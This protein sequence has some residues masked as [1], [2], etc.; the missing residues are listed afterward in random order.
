MIIQQGSVNTTALVVPDLW[1]SIVPPANLNLNGVPSNVLGVVG[2]A[3]WGPVGKPVIVG[4]VANLY[5]FFGPIQ[6]RKYDLGTQ[7]AIAALQGANNFRCVR[8]S[9]ATDVAATIAVQTNCITL[10]A[11]YT[12]TLGNSIQ[13][14]LA[15]GSKVGTT[16]AI[17]GPPGYQLEVF[18]N[19]SGAGNAF[20]VA[21]AAA[22]NNGQSQARGPSQWVTAAAGVGVTAPALATS[23]LTGGTDGVTTITSTVL[24]G[25][26]TIP[27]KGMYALRGQGCA[28][29]LLA[30]ADDSSQW[31]TINTFGLAEG[32]Y[33]IQTGPAGDSI[34]AAVTAKQTTAGLDSYASKI[35]H[36]DW[37][38]WSDPYTNAIRLVSPQGFAAGKLAALSPEQSSLNKPLA[39]IVGTQKSG[40]PGTGINGC[41]TQADLAVLFQAGID[42]IA[43]PGAGGLNIWTVRCGH[44]SSSNPAINGDNYT[45]L[46]NYI[47]TSLNAGMGLY[48]G[49]L[50]NQRLFARIKGTLCSFFQNMLGQGLLGTLDG[51]LPF[52]VACDVG[53][54]PL[55]RTSLGYVQADV[56]VQYQG[57]NE[58]FIVNLQGGTT[59]TVAKQSGQ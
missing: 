58:K 15:T 12:G 44:N 10:T 45:R 55:A 39:G 53:N 51:S 47:A 24:V 48:I 20:W 59:V 22:I 29:A 9:D 33:M 30:D 7:V 41:Y 17:I 36:G 8:V 13:M 23:T 27:R 19:L 18:D 3:S 1:V 28:L 57:I 50:I 32:I 11:L 42:V 43:N 21:L 35:M 16:K 34:A 38:W 6:A 37:V 52:S 49:Q 14:T 2:T 31:T 40:L 4:D 26:D 5:A 46:T 56:A 54:N 25:S